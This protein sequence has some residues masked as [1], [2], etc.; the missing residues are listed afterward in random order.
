[1]SILLIMSKKKVLS[2]ISLLPISALVRRELVTQLRRKRSFILLVAIALMMVWMIGVAWPS[3]NVVW[4]MLPSISQTI[5]TG[6]S[7]M[8][9][10][11][12]ALFIPGLAATTIVV[13]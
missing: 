7:F 1:M 6:T 12:A 2:G 10:I 3:G 9:L 8:L 11:V 5:V 13:E 4:A